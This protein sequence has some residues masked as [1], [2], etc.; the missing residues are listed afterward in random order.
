MFEKKFLEEEV[1]DYVKKIVPELIIIN[2][3]NESGET[4]IFKKL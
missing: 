1:C 3:L 4:C 2:I